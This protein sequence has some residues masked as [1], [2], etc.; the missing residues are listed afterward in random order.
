M[1]ECHAGLSIGGGLQVLVS[2]IDV[3]VV[4]NILSFDD[5]ICSKY[6][7]TRLLGS[8]LNREALTYALQLCAQKFHQ[9]GKPV[10]VGHN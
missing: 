3:V 1:D 6:W 4:L 9:I 8:H 2:H 10:N 7:S 5:P